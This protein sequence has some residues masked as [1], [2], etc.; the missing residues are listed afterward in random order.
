MSVVYDLGEQFRVILTKTSLKIALL[1][2]YVDDVRQGTTVLRL[3]IRFDKISMECKWSMGAA[4][5]DNELKELKME[6]SNRRMVRVCQPA[7]NAINKDL[8]FTTKI[9]EDYKDGKVPTLDFKA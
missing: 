5:E 6:S 2:S 7:M 1:S 3:G 4:E 9:P 8:V